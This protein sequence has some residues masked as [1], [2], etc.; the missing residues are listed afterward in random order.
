[1]ADTPYYYLV[2]GLPELRL[3]DAAAP[4]TARGF[5]AD[6][7]EQLLPE[8]LEALQL[9]LEA[10][11]QGGEQLEA[12]EQSELRFLQEWAHFERSL[13]NLLA[14]LQLRKQKLPAQDALRGEDWLAEQLRRSTARDF[15]I[16]REFAHTEQVLQ[17]HAMPRLFER[18]QA[19]DQLRWDYI[20]ELNTF[21]Y[22]DI[23]QL[24]GF[25]VKLHLLKR[26]EPLR[27]DTGGMTLSQWLQ[28]LDIPAEVAETTSR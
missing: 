6:I 2:A 4:V 13:R 27:A 11:E 3:K 5:V 24:L 23:D 28:R 20:D 12:L 25:V 17:I 18:E 10:L 8:H 19:L 22:F 21:S 16:G 14:A 7:E 9:L 26:Y 15:G 1:M